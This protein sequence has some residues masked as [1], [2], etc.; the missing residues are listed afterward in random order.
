MSTTIEPTTAEELLMMPKDGFR[1]EL[2]K[3][4]LKKMSPAGSEHGAVAMNVAILLGQ[5]I[6]ANKLGVVFAAE[7]GFKLATDPDTVLA[8]D[9][10]FVRRE[11]IPQSGL[12]KAF[13]PGAPDLAV[14]VVSPGDTKKEVAEKVESWLT[15]GSSAVWVVNPKRRTVTIHRPQA[16]AVTLDEGDELDGQ[17]V[18]HGFRCNVSEIFA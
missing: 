6:K 3:G 16:E 14:E 1:Y 2:V 12:P 17:D 4:E 8:P 11:R 13:Y 9:V 10:S 7:T 5:Y 18:V 15:A